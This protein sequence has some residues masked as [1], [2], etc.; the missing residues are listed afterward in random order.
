MKHPTASRTDGGADRNGF[1]SAAV[2][3]LVMMLIAA[4]LAEVIRPTERIGAV[5][6][7]QKLESLVPT[8]F[9]EWKVDPFAGNTIVNPQV[10]ET[11]DRLYSD[12]LTRT[13]VD[14]AGRRVML[15]I[16][17]GMDQTDTAQVHRPEI[18]YPAQGFVL[19]SRNDGVLDLETIRIDVRRLRTRLGTR[20]EPVTY[21][22]VVGEQIATRPATKKWVELNYGLRG[23]VPDGLLFRVSSLG[24]DSQ[25]E[26]VA[27]DKFVQELLRSMSPDGQSRLIGQV[28]RS[29]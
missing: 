12:I 14:S 20:H 27:Q 13:Y 29:L 28:L 15:S 18:C 16:A 17:Y 3:I 23:R 19:E 1:S 11:L 26:F 22:I 6:G 5:R 2:V 8:A 4:A 9:G 25:Q 10:Q 21:W 7:A 24:S